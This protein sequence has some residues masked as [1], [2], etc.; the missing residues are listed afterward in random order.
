MSRLAAEEAL[1]QFR[2]LISSDFLASSGEAEISVKSR[3]NLL[4]GDSGILPEEPMVENLFDRKS[5]VSFLGR[6]GVSLR[7][8][9]SS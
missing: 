8:L 4:G 1:F 7:L 2:S 3:G 5:G 6:D 9:A